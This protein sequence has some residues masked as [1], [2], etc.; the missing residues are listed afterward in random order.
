[1]P[2]PEDDCQN[3]NK[4]AQDE[5]DWSQFETSVADDWGEV[6]KEELGVRQTIDWTLF[7]NSSEPTE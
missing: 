1:M 7:E 5:I 3:K 6:S 2:K 4:K